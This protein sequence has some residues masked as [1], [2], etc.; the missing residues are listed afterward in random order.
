VQLFVLGF[1]GGVEA[2]KIRE[3]DLGDDVGGVV[4][5]GEL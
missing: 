2:L 5:D 4:D 3:E 1:G